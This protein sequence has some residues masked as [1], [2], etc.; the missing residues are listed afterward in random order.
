MIHSSE[1]ENISPH[2]NV[3]IDQTIDWCS[4]FSTCTESLCHVYLCAA[5]IYPFSS[6]F[7]CV[8]VCV[9]DNMNSVLTGGLMYEH[10]SIHSAALLKHTHQCGSV[11]VIFN[12]K[13][14]QSF[15]QNRHPV[16]MYTWLYVCWE[17]QMH[18]FWGS[19]LVVWVNDADVYFGEPSL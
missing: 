9:R 13:H 3:I 7:T 2:N 8:C 1:Y 14:T 19:C 11:H 18:I 4:Q 6:R 5:F 15:I 16:L 10:I 17:M 12:Y